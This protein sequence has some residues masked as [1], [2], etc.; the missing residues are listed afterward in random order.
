MSVTDADPVGMAEFR[1][2][3]LRTL[4]AGI[5]GVG[6]VVAAIN[7][8]ALP[9]KPWQPLPALAGLS[10][11]AG[12]TYWA[13]RYG[14]VPATATMIVG[15][16][17]T[18]T[19]LL[20]LYP[21]SLLAGYFFLII[22]AA[23]G[24]LGWRAGLVSAVLASAIVV[25]LSRP[26][27]AVVTTDV[28][29]QALGFIWATLVLAWLSARP[30]SI[31]ATWAWSNYALTQ[32][33]TE[34]ARRGQGEL[35]RLSRS[36]SE[37]CDRLERVN[38]ELEDARE[39][40]EAARRMKAEFAA[41]VGHELRTPVNLIIGFSQMMASPRRG[42]YYDEPLP[43]CYRD[44]LAAIYRNA[45]HISSLV[46][47]ILDLSQIDAHRMA[48]RKEWINLVEVAEEAAATVQALYVDAGLYLH[49]E[50]PPEA[51]R[52]P[53]DPVRIRQVLINLLYNAVR[54][55][56]RGGV[57]I[58]A[59]RADEGVV[60]EVHDTGVGIPAEGLPRLFEEFRQF[61]APTRGR[62]GSGLGLAVCKRFVE[63]H[64]GNI[65]AQSA[66]ETGTTIAFSLP[67]HENVAVVPLE[68]TPIQTAL[69]G[70]NRPGVAVFDPEGDTAHVLDR[71]LDGY[72]VRRVKSLEQVTRLG[73][74]GEL[75][76]LIVTSP[77]DQ[78]AW[79]EHQHANPSL[80]SVPTLFC[81][82]RTRRAIA[83]TL[84]AVDYL[85][86][87]VSKDQL[88]RALRRLRQPIRTLALIE[89]DAGMRA[90]LSRM[91]HALSRRCRIDEADDGA[92]GLEL[93]RRQRPDVVL[94]D[95]LMPGVDGYTVLRE[96][97][98]DEGLRDIPV[99]VISAKG[100]NEGITAS[101]IGVSRPDGLSVGEATACLKASL[102]ALLLRRAGPDRDG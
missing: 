11:V 32:A 99:V 17:A 16:T 64:G 31:M 101:M 69:R 44:D 30:L 35:A 81:P 77:E 88:A 40:A 21:R 50:V 100:S 46:D 58:S 97:R 78:Q 66:P 29:V 60:V 72:R 26:P 57:T 34:E 42:S 5:L 71:Y 38:R 74:D 93:L 25:A 61:H 89:D 55:T 36:L 33:K 92:S 22:L 12:S 91:L 47:D 23:S 62:F 18:L 8:A 102:D 10:L 67:C 37:A 49:V 24:V 19:G 4:V 73:A 76:A 45:S 83:E 98:R 14:L 15:L 68:R 39:A 85:V 27:A 79:Y 94:L 53:A 2:E 13:L 56:H 7:G 9:D 43:D 48:L 84:G 65:W 87:P 52:V 95:L 70:P 75:R 90:L 80:T 20:L 63:L 82:L 41:T 6:L 59:R 54:F 86:K 96:L 51:P 1:V 28:A 3:T